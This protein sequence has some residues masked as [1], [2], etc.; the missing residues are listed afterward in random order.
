MALWN[1][2][3]VF[4]Q[5]TLALCWE[6]CGRMMWHW[7][8]RN[9]S[10]QRGKYNQKAGNYLSTTTGL[11]EPQMTTFYQQLGIRS[12]ANPGGRNV[13]HALRWTPVIVTSLGQR[14]GHAMIVA[15]HNR[16]SY[17]VINPC[18]VQVVNFGG[19]ADSCSAATIPIAEAQ[20][21]GNL[22][23]RIWYW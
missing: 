23:T 15:G 19:G 2:I 20:L 16:G 6:A 11:T 22:G 21:D 1:N 4:S 7:R 10:Q 5:R 8:Y 18:G 9:N 3:P 17:S 14:T 13:R 12:L